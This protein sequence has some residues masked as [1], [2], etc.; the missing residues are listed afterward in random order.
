FAQRNLVTRD[1][2]FNQL[3]TQGFDQKLNVQAQLEPFKEFNIDVNLDKTFTKN[4]SQLFKDT[5]GT[6]GHA[7]LTPY[8]TGGFSV[9]YIAFQTLFTKFDPNRTSDMFRNFEGYRQQLSRRVAENNPYWKQAGS[10]I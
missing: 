2:L 9:T 10:I 1:P 6:S 5:T 7:H 8:L 4:F 3:F